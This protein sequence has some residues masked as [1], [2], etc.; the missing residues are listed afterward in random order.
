MEILTRYDYCKD[1]L[2][3]MSLEDLVLH[4]LLLEKIPNNTEISLSF[5]DDETMASLNEQYRGLEGPTDVLSFECDDIEP[6]SQANAGCEDTRILGDIIIAPDVARTQA[7]LF[8]TTFQEEI[9][10]LVVH[11]T[12][13]L[14]GFD[15]IDD[16]E[17]EIM[18][19]REAEILQAWYSNR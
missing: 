8:G 12:L 9:E 17:A 1:E 3:D 4:T 10:L 2:A 14:C 7:P 15:H 6:D 13:H 18:E 19:N 16:E 11:G 5:V